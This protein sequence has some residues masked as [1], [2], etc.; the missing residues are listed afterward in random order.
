MKW[1]NEYYKNSVILDWYWHTTNFGDNLNKWLIE[2]LSN[3]K[4]VNINSNYD[5]TNHTVYSSIGSILQKNF[6]YKVDVWGSGCMYSSSTKYIINVNKIHAIRGKLS[7]KVAL[8]SSIQCPEIYGDPAILLP[9]FYQSKVKRKTHSIGLLPHYIDHDSEW[10]LKYKDCND[11][12]FIDILQPIE[13]VIDDINS[14]NYV[15]SSSLHGLIAADVYNIPSL[16]VEFSDK[17]RG[18]GF[19]FR[20]Y[21]SGI[22]YDHESYYPLQLRDTNKT[23]YQVEKCIKRHIKISKEIQMKLLKSCP[24]SD[25]GVLEN[26]K[27]K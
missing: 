26:A 10:V 22:D 13:K 9:L 27:N 4:V 18:N 14:C 19:K 7:R 3:K 20:D 15:I 1:K 5:F 8:N 21:Y 6:K 17:V 23:I 25:K 16:W 11:V 2:K 12:K 24:F